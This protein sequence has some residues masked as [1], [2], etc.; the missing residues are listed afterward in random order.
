MIRRALPVLAL[1]TAATLLAAAPALADEQVEAARKVL[2]GLAPKDSRVTGRSFYGLHVGRK[3]VGSLEVDVAPTTSGSESYHARAVGRV[4]VGDERAALEESGLLDR[5]LAPAV[6]EEREVEGATDKRPPVVR[7]L[8][9]GA[10]A[11]TLW[12]PVGPK[13]GTRSSVAPHRPLVHGL[14]ARLAFLRALDAKKKATYRVCDVDPETGAPR[15]LEL[16]V[17]AVEDDKLWPVLVRVLATRETTAYLLDPEAPPARR[18]V[19]WRKLD[20]ELEYVLAPDALGA[21]KDLP[22]APRPADGTPRA[23]ILA[24]LEAV[25]RRDAKRLEPLIEWASFQRSLGEKG[26]LEAWKKSFLEQMVARED[27]ADHGEHAKAVDLIARLKSDPVSADA[28]E[29]RVRIEGEKG[30]FRLVREKPQAAWKIAQM[31]D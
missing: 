19:R 28:L 20:A 31:P 1:A 4:A 15:E 5:M 3:N 16:E 26:E 30:I 23:T 8:E 12:R 7:R 18:V 6:L 11:F 9:R 17:T 27:H 2:T 21:A 25:E 13:E 14:A 24:Y 22:P 29:A 10:D